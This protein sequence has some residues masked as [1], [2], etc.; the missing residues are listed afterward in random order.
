MCPDESFVGAHFLCEGGHTRRRIRDHSRNHP[1]VGD[2]VLDAPIK[3]G[4]GDVTTCRHVATQGLPL[5]GK[6]RRRR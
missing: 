2:G 6:P 4:T 1:L 3:R 5:E